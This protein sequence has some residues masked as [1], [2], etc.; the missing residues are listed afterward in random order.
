MR[1]I[2]TAASIM[3]ALSSAA[4]GELNTAPT[5]N[6]VG[7]LCGWTPF[8]D[9]V[10]D[11]TADARCRA[12]VSGEVD[13]VIAGVEFSGKKLICVPDNTLG[14]AKFLVVQQ[15]YAA[16]PETYA[17]DFGRLVAD[18]LSHAWPCHK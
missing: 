9:T 12:F 7:K 5:G 2:V 6:G 3:V 11:A 15:Y 18:A 1:S 4:H 16:H 17:G 14:P 8:Q 13:G 10:R